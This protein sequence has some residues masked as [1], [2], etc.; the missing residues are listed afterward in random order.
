MADIDKM[1]R[2]PL[3]KGCDCTVTYTDLEFT[4]VSLMRDGSFEPEGTFKGYELLVGKNCLASACE[5]CALAGKPVKNRT[6][7]EDK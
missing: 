6:I 4:G 7:V 1:D 5:C 3:H 2:P